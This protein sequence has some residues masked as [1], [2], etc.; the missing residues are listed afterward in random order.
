MVAIDKVRRIRRIAAE[1][2]LRETALRI[3]RRYYRRIFPVRLP[4]HPFDIRHRVDTSGLIGGGLLGSGRTR[5]RHITAYWGIAPSAFHH[6]LARWN[7]TLPDSPYC[8]RDYVFL[9]VGCGK[10]RA[11][12]LASD[13]PFRRIVGVELNPRLVSIANKN[14]LKWKA[15][16][17]P[18]SDIVAL[19]DDAL[20]IALPES[21]VLLYVFNPFDEQAVQLM[22]DRLQT[23]SLTRSHPIDIVYITPD[24]ASLFALVPD[25]QLLWDGKAPLTPEE[26]AVDAFQTHS[27]DFR[28]Y[29]MPCHPKLF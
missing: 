8:C 10:G 19:H 29:R 11:L 13:L 5:D 9:D 28:I 4:V 7:E 24:H 22:L 25:L 27:L 21:P 14:L 15:S 23:L 20:E 16:A 2:G 12:M 1:V 17:H 6:S 18:C 3:L 26:T